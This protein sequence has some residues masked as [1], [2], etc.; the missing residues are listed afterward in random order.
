LADPHYLVTGAGGFVGKRMAARLLEAGFEVSLWTRDLGD[1]RDT[2]A[3]GSELQKI[4][5]STVG[6]GRDD[7]QA[8][9]EEVRM[10]ANL[11]FAMPPSCRMIQFGSMAEYGRPG[12]LAE[13]DPRYPDTSYGLAKASATDF[14][15]ATRTTHSLDI[16]VLRLF[17]VYGPGEAAQRLLP[18]LVRR[19]SVGEP[20]PMS[21]GLQVRDFVHVDD[22]CKAVLTLAS[23]PVWSTPL[24][25]LGTGQGVSVRHV[26]EYAADILG[27]DRSLLQFG[28]VARKTV[29]QPLLVAD[30]ASLARNIEA[31]MQNWMVQHSSVVSEFVL[32][33]TEDAA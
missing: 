33:L 3:V 1:L 8:V 30:T 11:A 25:N 2:E 28:A 23:K 31:P 12:I 26:C 20:F 27:A 16:N 17:G 13:T 4:A 10:S 32:G 6:L 7:W 14:A 19:L 29:D 21:D 5:P 15:L 22:V 18:S 24:L 9:A